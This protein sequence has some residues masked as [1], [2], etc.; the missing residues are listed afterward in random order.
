[1]VDKEYLNLFILLSS[2][3]TLKIKPTLFTILKFNTILVKYDLIFILGKQL[4]DFKEIIKNIKK[5]ENL[6]HDKE[7]ANIL[8]LKNDNFS[9]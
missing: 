9:E 4:L 7:V 2:H 1:M 5:I 8:G 6:K 3:W